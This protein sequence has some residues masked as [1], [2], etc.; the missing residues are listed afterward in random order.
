[1]AVITGNC[2]RPFLSENK[3]ANCFFLSLFTSAH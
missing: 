2:R 1:M 3:A